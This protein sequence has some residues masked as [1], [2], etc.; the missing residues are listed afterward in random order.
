MSIETPRILEQQT[1]RLPISAFGALA[2]VG[3]I[4]AI[5]VGLTRPEIIDFA[6]PD[7]FAYTAQPMVWIFGAATLLPCLAYARNAGTSIRFGLLLWFVLGTITFTK[8]FSYIRLPGEPIFVTDVLLAVLILSLIIF[9]PRLRTNLRSTAGKFLLCYLGIGAFTLFR[10]VLAGHPVLLSLRDAAIT[11]YALFFL[12]GYL[13]ACDPRKLLLLGKIFFLGSAL[14]SV[15]AIFY[16]LHY[17]QYGYGVHLTPG[18][19]YATA[20]LGV[21]LVGFENGFIH[22]GLWTYGLAFLFAIGVLLSDARTNYL[23]L[24]LMLVAAFLFV[25]KARRRRR[26]RALKPLLRGAIVL[27]LLVV[28]LSATPVAHKFV[29]A[30]LKMAY[31]GLFTPKQDPDAMWRLAAWVTAVDIFLRQPVLGV[32]YGSP[33]RFEFQLNAKSRKINVD[34]KPH[35]TYLTVLYQMGLIGILPLLA[36]LLYFFFRAFSYLRGALF[37]DAPCL[38][39]TIFQIVLVTLGMFNLVLETPFYGSIFWLNLGIGFWLIERKVNLQPS[40][41][42]L[43]ARLW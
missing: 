43:M 21:L 9:N 11:W 34:A 30:G 8:D 1:P 33:F 23:A 31:Q 38:L 16:F 35:N 15:V 41:G 27:T 19:I 2:A 18:G 26:L 5:M 36:I 28:I 32:G 42:Q 25:P 4:I 10:S 3:V 7:T 6:S 17:P 13:C 22:K 29:T 14:T 40:A 37:N 39:V 12:V 20:A 24:C